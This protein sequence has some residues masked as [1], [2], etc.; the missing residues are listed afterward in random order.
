MTLWERIQSALAPAR[1]VSADVEKQ[2]RLAT[3]ALLLEICRADFEVRREEMESIV[4]AVRGTFGLTRADTR[5]LLDAAETEADCAV[6]LQIYTSLI[7]EYSTAAQ[8]HQLI[9]DLWR[10]AF[11][12]GE[13]HRLEESLIGKIGGLLHVAPAKVATLRDKIAATLDGAGGPNQQPA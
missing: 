10:V 7:N 1:P 13:L 12:D 9:E 5:E 11:S 6:S 4:Q 8:K 3:G 2:L